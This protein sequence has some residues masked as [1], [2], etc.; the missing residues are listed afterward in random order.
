VE[1]RLTADDARKALV[2]AAEEALVPVF[3]IDDHQTGHD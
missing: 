2:E 1:G 3:D